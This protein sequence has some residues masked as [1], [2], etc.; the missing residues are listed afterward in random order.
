[1]I[2]RQLQYRPTPQYM[3]DLQKK[4]TLR[5]YPIPSTINILLVVFHAFTYAGMA[6]GMPILLRTYPGYIGLWFLLGSV[7]TL[8]QAAQA[9]S[10]AHE[11]FHDLL[12][13]NKDINY[14][15]SRVMS[16]CFGMPLYI[17]RYVHA[18]HHRTNGTYK[19]LGRHEL[20]PPNLLM[21]WVE[22]LGGMQPVLRTLLL[23]CF[24][25]KKYHGKFHEFLLK[26]KGDKLRDMRV[27]MVFIVLTRIIT[28]YLWGLDYLL[29]W[30]WFSWLG[31][32]F[33]SFYCPIFHQ[34]GPMTDK[35]N[36]WNLYLPAPLRLCFL[37]F[38]MHQIHHLYPSVPWIY[39]PK[40]W[41]EIGAQWDATLWHGTLTQIIYHHRDIRTIRK[42]Y[43]DYLES[44]K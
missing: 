26:A 35:W 32:F 44:Q 3:L 31:D 16:I 13:H 2:K 34:G 10:I 17:F 8:F 9:Y 11:G 20:A 7:V 43:N 41:K 29:L 21:A 22:L 30:I 38:N 42:Q 27:D 4:Y 28:L 12:H 15:L 24:L 25:P 14:L 39:Y 33:I 40:I 36:S 37:N 1:M 19:D 23:A 6:Y 5:S 18:I